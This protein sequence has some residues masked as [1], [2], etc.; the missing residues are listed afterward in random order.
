M[1]AAFH[2]LQEKPAPNAPRRWVD[3]LVEVLCSNWRG[4]SSQMKTANPCFELVYLVH[5][6]YYTLLLCLVDYSCMSINS[7]NGT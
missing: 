6:I 3:Y 1:C 7:I 2:T 4:F 5:G